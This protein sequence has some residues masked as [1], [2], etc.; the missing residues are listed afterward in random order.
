MFLEPESPQE[1]KPAEVQVTEVKDNPAEDKEEVKDS[2][3]ASDDEVKDAWDA[4][5]EDEVSEAATGFKFIVFFFFS[6]NYDFCREK[7]VR[8]I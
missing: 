7:C 8:Y 3:D 4:E 5:S 6:Y 2:W 1:E